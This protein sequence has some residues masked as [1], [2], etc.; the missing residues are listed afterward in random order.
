MVTLQKSESVK[1]NLHEWKW[2]SKRVIIIPKQVK[3]T[4]KRVKIPPK[5]WN[6]LFWGGGTLTEGQPK[7][8]ELSLSKLPQKVKFTLL[9]W[10]SLNCFRMIFTCFVSDFHLVRVDFTLS[11]FYRV[12]ISLFYIKSDISWQWR[13]VN[14]W[15][16]ILL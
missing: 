1:T 7:T 4:P 2:P 13:N 5:E 6:S 8:K 14:W 10:L 15:D 11:L 9:K 16:I 12:T 3:I